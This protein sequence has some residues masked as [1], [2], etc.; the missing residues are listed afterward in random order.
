MSN[1]PSV[2][3]LLSIPAHGVRFGMRQNMQ[4]EDE[5]DDDGTHRVRVGGFGV[6]PKLAIGFSV[7]AIDRACR[8][9]AGW[10]GV[11]AQRLHSAAREIMRRAG[12]G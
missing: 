9:L 10:D 12:I 8:L 3:G 1:T 4:V 6:P 5:P 11:D 7:L 2:Y